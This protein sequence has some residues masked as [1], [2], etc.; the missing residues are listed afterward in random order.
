MLEKQEPLDQYVNGLPNVAQ[1]IA[2]QLERMILDGTLAPGHRLVQTDIAERFGVSRLPVRDAL[3][4]LEKK[5]LAV[6]QPRRGMIVRPIEAKEVRELF[7]LRLVLEGYAFS[8]SAPLL[9]E[10]DLERAERLVGQQEATD[11]FVQLMG[12]DEQFHLLLLTRFDNSEA[13]KHIGQ[14]WRRIKVMRSFA[15]DVRDW[16]AHSVESHRQILSMLRGK[17]FKEAQ[18]CL[19]SGIRRGRDEILEQVAVLNR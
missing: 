12:I 4:I 19:E 18:Q 11:D 1:F 17:K 8:I 5:E 15:R 7:E 6:N 3:Q 16:K 10:S 9:A 13:M 2:E 14:V